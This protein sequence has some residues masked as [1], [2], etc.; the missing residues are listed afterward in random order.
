MAIPTLTYYSVSADLTTLSA[1]LNG[2]AM[3]C[4]QNAL[5]WGFAFL[6][7][8]WR[9]T[10]T[11]VTA[12][13]KNASGGA[14]AVLASG[15][16]SAIMPFVLAM[17]LT[18]SM[19]QGT[20]QVESTIN[21]AL[22][23]VDHVPL[24]ISA[25]PVAG[26]I[27]SQNLNQVISTAFQSVNSEYPVISASANGF[28]NPLKVLLTAR[29]AMMR[30]G[31]VDSEVK[32]VLA[33][34]L[35]PDSGVNFA[36]I[37]NMVMNAGN[38][39]ATSATSIE[40]NGQNPTALGALLYQAS[41]NTNGMVNDPGLD[42]V[43]MLSCA[44]AV[45]V[46]ANDIT[47][48]L[49]SGEFPRVIQGA[50]NGM[51]APVPGA[52]YSFNTVASQYNAV[53]TASTLGSVFSGGTGQ[54]NAEFMNLLFAE[55]VQNDLNCLRATSNDLTQC[56]ATALQAAEVERNNIQ[57]AASEVPMLR[58]AGSFGNYLIALI[59]GLGP[60][61]IMFMMF[62]GVDAGKSVKTAA[63]IIVWPLLVVN[64]GAEL[65][66]AMISI[67]IANYLQSIRQ[68]GWISQATT[69]A[70]YKELSLQI[71]TG[72]HI[73]ASLPVLMSLIFGL[74]E[75]SAMTSVASTIAPRSNDTTENLAPKP[76]ATLPMFENSSVAH[77]TQLANGHANLQMQ[78]SLDAVSTSDK[79]G[80]L[81]KDA[82]RSLT[83][84][85]T[86]SSSIEQGQQNLHSWHE[87]V[88][89]HD[90]SGFGID[91]QIGEQIAYNWAHNLNASRNR[92]TG[93]ST[94]GLK[95][96]ENSSTASLGLSG[97]LSASTVEGPGASLSGSASAG[98]STSSGDRLQRA[99]DAGS[100]TAYDDSNALSTAI[101]DTLASNRSTSAGQQAAKDLS[102]SLQTQQT[103]QR[104]LSQ[105]DSSTDATAQAVHESSGF[106]EASAQIKAPELLWQKDANP[107]FRAFQTLDGHQ[108][109]G[110]A[111]AQ[112]YMQI[113]ARD[114]ASGATGRVLND[115]EGQSMVNRHRAAVLMAQDA[116]AP[117]ADRAI[118]TA[119]LVGEGQAM[120]HM[121]FMPGDTTM[122]DMNIA[123][124]G[125]QTGVNAKGLRDA[126]Q[127]NAPALPVPAVSP[128]RRSSVAESGLEHVPSHLHQPTT[129]HAPTMPL[130]PMPAA[131]HPN[132]L[133]QS[134][135]DLDPAFKMMVEGNMSHVGNTVA[136]K[137]NNSVAQAEH[138]GLGDAGPGTARRTASNVVDNVADMARKAGSPSRTSLNPDVAPQDPQ[139]GAPGA[140]PSPKEPSRF[141]RR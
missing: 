64:V 131:G 100:N 4:Q 83:N 113:A 50:V 67:D 48:A 37:Q 5:I 96:N 81:S 94:T 136:A 2:V 68:G 117:V 39:G 111:G 140:S 11:P 1:I 134:T 40:I 108:F 3:V 10:A 114:A 35:G 82:S 80:D 33:S 79:F 26:S 112:R 125:D 93:E 92:H 84:A 7:S 88:Q 14:G 141:V 73:M 85:Q 32:T 58:Y 133:S 34:C 91:N 21:G 55:M 132:L 129:G 106:V 23:E 22:T 53:I 62:A 71:G 20:V 63:H 61:I 139:T 138:A 30:L 70:A 128:T 95:S 137:V 72:S 105:V 119:F 44:A 16:M 45:N 127:R 59:I 25:I 56:E 118:A 86:R 66:N 38:T 36:N 65:V 104:T 126:V 60:V 9:L 89:K 17:M 101:H 76:A 24:A 54:S 115:P 12:A 51:D 102:Q 99:T 107:E 27:L 57:E 130:P 41:L 123:Q 110:H 103:F 69:F 52:D 121:R 98:T 43:N 124:P 116:N 42:S 97:G 109:E 13:L 15:S 122:K 19:L 90:F 29:T 6:V 31:G 75:S 120:Q 49:N 77:A 18:N 87:A 28:L 74:G 46:V 8:L 135:P 78:G 47:N